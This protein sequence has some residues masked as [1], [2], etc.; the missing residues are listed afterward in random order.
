[1]GS[2]AGQGGSQTGA[3]LV[4]RSCHS[5]QEARAAESDGASYIIFGPVFAT[6]SKAQ[7]GAPLGLERLAE[8]CAAVRTPVLAIGGITAGNAGECRRAGAAGIAAVRLFQDAADIGAAVR[9][10]RMLRP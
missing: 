9:E 4:G 7:Y 10:L 2:K 1:M 8:V 6:P 5:L 3:F